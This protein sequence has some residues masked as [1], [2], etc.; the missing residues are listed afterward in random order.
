MSKFNNKIPFQAI[1][2]SQLSPS[3]FNGALSIQTPFEEDDSCRAIA[4]SKTLSRLLARVTKKEQICC[5]SKLGPSQAST[6]VSQIPIF[7]DVFLKNLK[8]K[9]PF[10]PPS[11]FALYFCS[12]NT[13]FSK[14]FFWAYSMHFLLCKSIAL[15]FLKKATRDSFRDSFFAA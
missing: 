14:Y 6:K 2:G 8:L 5:W 10:S 7:C 9:C 4:R 12:T 13:K 11:N 3:V 15:Y 1:E